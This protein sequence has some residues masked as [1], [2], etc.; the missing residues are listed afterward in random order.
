MILILI[1][2]I[3]IIIIIITIVI[4]IIKIII[5]IL[6]IEIFKICL[7]SKIKFFNYLKFERKHWNKN[8]HF[9]SQV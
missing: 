3:I 1:L 7:S 8:V 6:K 5:I 4:I 2:I 9:C